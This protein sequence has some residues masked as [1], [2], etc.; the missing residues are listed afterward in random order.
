MVPIKFEASQTYVPSSDGWTLSMRRPLPGTS[1]TLSRSRSRSWRFHWMSGWGSPLTW[2]SVKMIYYRKRSTFT[3]VSFTL[4]IEEDDFRIFCQYLL[5]HL[6]P[7]IN[8]K[9]LCKLWH[10]CTA[11]WKAGVGIINEFYYVCV[12]VGWG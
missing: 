6:D 4:L 10:R 8:I 11:F 12:S 2:G 9:V 3:I 7:K 5:F 1:L